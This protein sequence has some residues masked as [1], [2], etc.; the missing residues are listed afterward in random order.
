MQDRLISGC[1]RHA[2][3]HLQPRINELYSMIMARGGKI[4]S[5]LPQ[6]PLLPDS[7]PYPQVDKATIPLTRADENPC[8]STIQRRSS[9]KTRGRKSADGQC[10]DDDGFGEIG[11][12]TNCGFPT[13]ISVHIDAQHEP[14]S[15]WANWAPS[16]N[17]GN[18]MPGRLFFRNSF[19]QRKRK[20]YP[21]Q[22]QVHNHARRDH[23]LHTPP[24]QYAG[25]HHTPS[26]YRM[27]HSQRENK[28]KVKHGNEVRQHP[29]SQ[30][31]SDILKL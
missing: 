25:S 14:V 8:V 29:S 15:D 4:P 2:G 22:G 21:Y 19:S 13:N 6:Y 9:F 1:M 17:S 10:P 23:M 24:Y 26:E 11:F 30:S 16:E 12:K 3:L 28:W 18:N 5:S 27:H 20:R 7:P 31:S